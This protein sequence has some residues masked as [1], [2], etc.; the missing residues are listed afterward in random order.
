MLLKWK[1]LLFQ[2]QFL[3]AKK[4]S[5]GGLVQ[6]DTKRK[7]EVALEVKK[8]GEAKTIPF[9]KVLCYL[10]LSSASLALVS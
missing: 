3:L 1:K 4:A 7:R 10:L 2:K 6:A 8:R 5:N 9:A